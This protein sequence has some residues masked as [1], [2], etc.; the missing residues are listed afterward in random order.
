MAIQAGTYNFGPDNAT[1]VVKTGRTGAAAAA[2]HDLDIEVQS[3]SA[4][5][6]VGDASSLELSADP[7]SLH[8]L[9]G[10][11]GKKGLSDKDK[12]NIRKSIDKDILK[13]KGISFSSSSVTTSDSGLAVSGTLEIAGGSSPVSLSLSEAGGTLRAST[14]VKQSDFGIE[15]FTALFGALKVVDEVE[16]VVEAKL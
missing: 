8:V 6:T 5:L 16:V 3:W 9:K 4:T 2:G 13:G 10:T 7:T 12:A 11:G 14:T 1:L 15:Q